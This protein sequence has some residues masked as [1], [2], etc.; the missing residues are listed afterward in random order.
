[1]TFSEYENLHLS[2]Q[3]KFNEEK[4]R[5][6]NLIGKNH[7]HLSD[8][9]WKEALLRDM[10]RYFLR[11]QRMRVRTG[12][13]RSGDT[14]NPGENFDITTQQDILVV[15]PYRNFK[16]D[17]FFKNDDFV[18][19]KPNIVEAI[20]EVKTRL[21]DE[22]AIINK[23]AE[24]AG[25]I[26][27][28]RNGEH[29]EE[30][31]ETSRPWAGLFVY[32]DSEPTGDQQKKKEVFTDRTDKLLR[33]LKTA[34]AQSSPNGKKEDRVVDCVVLGDRCVVRFI[35]H[36]DPELGLGWVSYVYDPLADVDQVDGFQA[37][38]YFVSQMIW[39][40]TRN[41]TEEIKN[42]WFPYRQPKLRFISLNRND[43]EIVTL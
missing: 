38:A 7:H 3:K 29:T 9:E 43:Q 39:R 14:Q 15:Q 40:L 25:L 37:Q 23:L 22:T 8:G 11:Q 42:F 24:A 13:V 4:D 10:I 27:R 33:A 20:I 26:R 16:L 2:I 6:V 5:V 28:L 19:V 31:S 12:F 18:I 34:A 36:P 1:M 17:Y 35:H 30:H 41:K 32:N 21:S